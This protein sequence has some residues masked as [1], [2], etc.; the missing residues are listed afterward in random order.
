MRALDGIDCLVHRGSLVAL[1]GANGSG[2]STLL[3]IIAG[4]I[5]PDA[6]TVEVLGAVPSTS[7]ET[8]AAMTG[9]AGQDSA[10]DPEIT[11]I[12]TL[13]LFHALRGLPYAGR[14]AC[15]EAVIDMFEMESF[16]DRRVGGY[17]GG[18]RQR[19]H[20]ALETMH[21]PEL[22]LLDEPSASLDPAGRQALW[23][24][25]RQ[26]RGD[27]RTVV[28]VTHD[29][30]DVESFCDR[31]LVMR[32]SAIV[33]DGAPEELVAAF[34]RARTT[35]ELTVAPDDPDALRDDLE[36][37]LDG[38]RIEVH[39]STITITRGRAPEGSE[40]A[41]DLLR[42][43]GIVFTRFEQLPPD[44]VSAFIALT[45]SRPAGP[46]PTGPRR[47]GGP[48]SGSLDSRPHLRAGGRGRDE[49]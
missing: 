24:G 9:Y 18:Q 43:R 37:A 21:A 26:W 47:A 29:L 1:A 16:C 5:A 17:S 33:A 31:I 23:R 27:E 20:L 3:R 13:R 45:G 42:A 41:L 46:R 39:G 35:V 10:L 12:E 2:K 25:L 40:P 14:A 19:L 8:F 30:A 28:V 38:C 15:L 4:I 7:D 11:G 36:R 34:G 6:G 49:S 48:G 32:D 22:L 44:L